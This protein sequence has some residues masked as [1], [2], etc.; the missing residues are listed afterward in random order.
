MAATAAP[1]ADAEMAAEAAAGGAAPEG[2][3]GTEDTGAGG[4]AVAAAAAAAAGG[5]GAAVVTAGTAAAAALGSAKQRFEMLLVSPQDAPVII[6]QR[7]VRGRLTREVYRALKVSTKN[8]EEEIEEDKGKER[9]AFVLSGSK[10]LR[11]SP[12]LATV[13]GVGVSFLVL[14]QAF[15]PFMSQECGNACLLRK[16]LAD[17]ARHKLA[18]TFEGS[19]RSVKVSNED[20]TFGFPLSLFRRWSETAKLVS[21]P[22]PGERPSTL[23]PCASSARRKSSSHSPVS[24]LAFAMS[25]SF[26][27]M[28]VCINLVITIHHRRPQPNKPTPAG[29]HH[30]PSLHARLEVPHG[31]AAARGGHQDSGG[32]AREAE[33]RQGQ[34]GTG[35]EGHPGA[36]AAVVAAAVSDVKLHRS[37]WRSV[38]THRLSMLGHP[39]RY[40]SCFR[41]FWC[42]SCLSYC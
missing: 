36:V 38:L 2:L 25:C 21:A 35:G 10:V 17:H 26:F 4:N 7:L 37:T 11:C 8:Q 14:F 3:E 42:C 40:T 15:A 33:P 13:A 30:H 19:H 29:H 5:A 1:A 39:R 18:A 24:L 28:A 32:V 23:R 6:I 31:Q 16:L 9:K 27:I 20:S 22:P 34:E 41:K 12:G